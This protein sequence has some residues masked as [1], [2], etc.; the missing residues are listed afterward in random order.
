[1]EFTKEELQREHQYNLRMR[2]LYPYTVN[3]NHLNLEPRLRVKPT[4][5]GH[6]HKNNFY[7]VLPDEIRVWLEN[8]EIEYYI[9]T[10][11]VEKLI[12]FSNL[13]DSISFKL[14]FC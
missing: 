3:I 4:F 10:Y 14:K 13:Q 9:D 1:M 12:R 8:H 7:Y 6:S 11:G 5:L 2:T